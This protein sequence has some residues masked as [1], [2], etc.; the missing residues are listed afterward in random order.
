MA[1]KPV[2]PTISHR[3]SVSSH[4]MVF[5]PERIGA[6]CATNHS[7]HLDLNISGRPEFYSFAMMR[8]D[9]AEVAGR[10]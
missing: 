7:D 1:I 4:S 3:S 5:D 8:V 9:M 2:P 6:A 10:C